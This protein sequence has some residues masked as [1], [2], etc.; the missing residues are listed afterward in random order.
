MA[1]DG[2]RLN[3]IDNNCAVSFLGPAHAAKAI[4]AACSHGATTWQE[5]LGRTQRYDPDWT[6]DTRRGLLQFEEHHIP[7]EDPISPAEPTFDA[8]YPFRIWDAETR[9]SSLE[10]GMLGLVIF[11]LKEQRIIQVQNS[12]SDLQRQ[13]RGR[14]R[15]NGRPTPTIYHYKLPEDWAILP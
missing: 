9:K 7:C 6:S 2:F 14:V 8:A 13:G 4:A 3:I 10:P 11:N 1:H 15:L 5:V 12:Y